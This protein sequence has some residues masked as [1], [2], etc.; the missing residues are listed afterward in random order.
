[1][2]NVSVASLLIAGLLS[3]CHTHDRAEISFMLDADPSECNRI[4]EIRAD[5]VLDVIGSEYC[6]VTDEYGNEL[7]SQI[8]Y[9]NHLIFQLPDSVSGR[10]SYFIHPADTVH[11]YEAAVAGRLYPERAD[12]VAWENEIVGFRIYG[13][14]TQAKG[15]E[16]YGYDIFFKYPDKGLVLERLYEPET[17]PATWE[18]HDSLAAIDPRLAEEFVKTFS[19]HLDH[20]LGMDCYAVGPTL[21]AGVAALLDNDS[22]SF[23]WCYSKA[24]VLDNGPIRFSVALDF[25]PRVVGNDTITE[26][27]IISLDSGSHLNRCTVWFDGLSTEKDIAVG[28]PLRDESD[29]VADTKKGILAYADPTQGPDNGKALLGLVTDRQDS[30]YI[31]K[32]GH[33]LLKCKLQPHQRFTY[34]WGFAWDR[35]D[36]KDM[37]T[38]ES[39]LSSYT[40]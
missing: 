16:S 12:D 4:V 24:E 6:Y 19:Y 26:R 23:P 14:A 5:S 2:K 7:P 38:W 3:A 31:V 18:K 1:M 30:E 29:V 28:F 27:R 35:T 10:M 15:E 13:P 37:T 17:N 21:G 11:S 36:I 33:A 25:A 20:G 32:E 8:T 40:E 39:I 9:D 22:I 34:R